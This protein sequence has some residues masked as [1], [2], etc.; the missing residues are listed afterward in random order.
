MAARKGKRLSIAPRG[1]LLF[2]ALIAANLFLAAGYANR[3]SATAMICGLAVSI[4]LTLLIGIFVFKLMDTVDNGI[5]LL[6]AQDY[7]SRL[8]KV[9]QP[10][11]DAIVALFNELMDSLKSERQTRE[12]KNL[13]LQQLID[14]SDQGIVIMNLDDTIMQT[15]AAADDMLRSIDI[16]ELDDG[17]TATLRAADGMIFRVMRQ[18]FFDRG[19]RRT[20]YLI[21]TLTEEVR[22]IE[23]DTYGKVIRTIAHEVNNTLGGIDSVMQIVSNVS[24]PDIAEVIESCRERNQMLTDFIS[25]Y[26]YLVKIPE[27]RTVSMDLAESI[28]HLKP[29]ITYYAN[30]AGIQVKYNLD[31]SATVDLDPV[32]WEQA[33]INIIKNAV[34]SITKAERSDGLIEIS[35]DS[36]GSIAITDNGCGISPDQVPLLHT[37][38]YTTKPDGQG[39]GMMLI[40]EIL[41]RHECKFT[42]FTDKYTKKTHF[43]IIFPIES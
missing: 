7:A 17:E 41:R 23:R 8:R 24:E 40:R 31:E 42:L 15:N 32:L 28:E 13:F 20:F 22:N 34:E 3:F 14:A 29:F 1:K 26:A 12:E 16:P 4:L 19:F 6:K 43:H 36:R 38:F 25:A 30:N 18:S 9:G 5:N 21:E 33:I 10:E 11:A 37:P 35:I 27:A 39:I 2:Y